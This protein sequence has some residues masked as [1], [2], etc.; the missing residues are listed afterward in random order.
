MA[1]AGW[2]QVTQARP[3]VPSGA[4]NGWPRVSTVPDVLR[5]PR[6]PAAFA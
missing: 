4:K 6:A 5:I 2:W 1:S 3:F